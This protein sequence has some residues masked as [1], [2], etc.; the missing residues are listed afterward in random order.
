MDNLERKQMLERESAVVDHLNQLIGKAKS[1]ESASHC[2]DDQEFVTGMTLSE[3]HSELLAFL[4]AERDC[5]YE[6]CT[7]GEGN[8]DDE[9]DI[10]ELA[11]LDAMI[12]RARAAQ[13]V[14]R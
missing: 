1:A 8:T 6:C 9:G 12:D 11:R 7:D 14:A 5:F 2:D 3:S 10:A 13:G 4:I